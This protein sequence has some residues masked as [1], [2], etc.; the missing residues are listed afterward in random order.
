M[1][2]T[3][4][5]IAAAILFAGPS[6]AAAE[7]VRP[8]AR[9]VVYDLVK[10]GRHLKNS[11]LGKLLADPEM[12]NFLDAH[13]QTGDSPVPGLLKELLGSGARDDAADRP[14]EIRLDL[15]LLGLHKNRIRMT[16][17]LSAPAD[18][19]FFRGAYV[20]IRQKLA[21]KLTPDALIE[22]SENG[23]TRLM[24]KV[25]NAD[26]WGVG[27][28]KT[29]FVFATVCDDVKG[30]LEIGG[31]PV[32]A[33]P[34]ALRLARVT[35]GYATP[36]LEAFVDLEHFFTLA[37]KGY[38]EEVA[39]GSSGILPADDVMR[40]SDLKGA[41]YAA[42]FAEGKTDE[43][44]MLI[45]PEIDKSPAWSF[46]R[47]GAGQLASLRN[48]PNGSALT[49]YKGM[50]PLK[51]FENVLRL[52]SAENKKSGEKIERA[53]KIMKSVMGVDIRKDVLRRVGGDFSLGL[54]FSVEAGGPGW[55]L[56][57]PVE[58][59]ET[60]ETA[61]QVLGMLF[62]DNTRAFVQNARTDVYT[63]KTEAGALAMKYAFYDTGTNNALL[64][65]DLALIA[66]GRKKEVSALGLK[67]ARDTEGAI[68]IDLPSTALKIIPALKL[69]ALFSNKERALP[70]AGLFTRHL[71]RDTFIVA[72]TP[73][74]VTFS[75]AT[76]NGGSWPYL[77][78]GFCALPEI[79]RNVIDAHHEK[80]LETDMLA[81]LSGVVR[82][83]PEK[84]VEPGAAT[85][86]NLS[87]LLGSAA[88]M[89]LLVVEAQREKP[90]IPKDFETAIRDGFFGKCSFALVQTATG[91]L[92]LSRVVL[93]GG[94]PV[95]LP[96]G[97]VKWLDRGAALEM[98]EIF[99]I[100]RLEAVVRPKVD[101]ADPVASFFTLPKARD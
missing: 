52:L 57:V 100:P 25:A 94:A 80:R 89:R 45:V 76:E 81:R 60:F 37:K 49:V 73:D 36:A 74:A 90:A 50:D 9:I 88:H 98:L 42:V 69:A 38:Y 97:D 7:E 15:M 19:D 53:I 82:S 78:S 3:C 47:H 75:S 41:Y 10:T 79:L 5:I 2:F 67:I 95:M 24:V 72:T 64:S 92:I 27:Y 21:G 29:T 56:A 33:T 86:D 58:R 13:D 85:P 22:T 6:A 32:P 87:K 70:P 20:K 23:G 46:F 34:D 12:L 91:P 96:G 28:T 93:K 68:E 48:M 71:T 35:A 4:R 18:T 101:I 62:H 26:P 17:T 31:P 30:L 84:S 83:F 65:N 61:L 59:K 1:R 8:L 55:L 40:Y 99:K 54:A 44:M 63:L 77:L 51:T 11:G 66:A 16:A 14:A 39:I 43:K